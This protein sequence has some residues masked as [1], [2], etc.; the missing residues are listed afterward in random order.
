MVL[1][2]CSGLPQQVDWL[3]LYAGH[4]PSKA[5]SLDISAAGRLELACA[6]TCM[7]PQ[8]LL[9][10]HHHQRQQPHAATGSSLQRRRAAMP[11]NHLRR[12]AAAAAH[13]LALWH[14]HSMLNPWQL[15]MLVPLLPHRPATA[16]AAVMQLQAWGFLAL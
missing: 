12:R 6:H 5:V 3:L 16:L 2:S 14:N 13:R 15:A 11:H 4:D 1:S 10:R 8:Q 9:G 7:L